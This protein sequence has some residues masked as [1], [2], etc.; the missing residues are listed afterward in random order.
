MMFTRASVGTCSE[1]GHLGS[2]RQ[3]RGM[4]QHWLLKGI[5]LSRVSLDSVQNAFNKHMEVSLSA[6][7]QGPFITQWVP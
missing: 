4:R 5:Y 6:S 7:L 3:T 1:G 2:R